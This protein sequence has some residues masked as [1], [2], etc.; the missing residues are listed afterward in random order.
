VADG[1]ATIWVLRD[2]APVAVTVEIGSSDGTHTAVTGSDLKEND[3]AI[4]GA[5]TSS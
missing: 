2:G 4:V 1:K 3:A 5:R